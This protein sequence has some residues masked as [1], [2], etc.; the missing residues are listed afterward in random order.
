[1]KVYL[2]RCV[3][4]VTGVDA[5]PLAVSGTFDGVTFRG[6]LLAQFIQ[7][8]FGAGG[9]MQCGPVVAR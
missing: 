9:A 5:V 1:M 2:T 8:D 6:S 4:G 3:C 7:I